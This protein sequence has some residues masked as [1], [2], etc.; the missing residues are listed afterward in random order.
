MK[1]NLS[2]QSFRPQPTIVI[3]DVTDVYAQ[4]N[5]LLCRSSALHSCHS[6]SQGMKNLE[7]W[8]RKV[9]LAEP[10]HFTAFKVV[11]PSVLHFGHGPREGAQQNLPE[12]EGKYRK[13]QIS[14]Q[15]QIKSITEKPPSLL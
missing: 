9:L 2:L 10:L 5:T 11:F 14:L 15:L 12:E 6:R 8:I 1:G 7:K 3:S 4:M 13:R